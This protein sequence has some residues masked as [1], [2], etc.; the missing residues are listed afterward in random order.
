M[1]R[2]RLLLSNKHGSQLPPMKP[3]MENV[4]LTCDLAV[5]DV[6]LLTAALRDLH[7]RYPGRFQTGLRT[8]FHE[9]YEHNP[10][11][12]THSN[13]SAKTIECSY[14]LIE[15]SN[16]APYH[17]IHGFHKFLGEQLGV[18]IEPTEFKGDV[19]L[20]GD[21]KSWDSQVGELMGEEIPFWI[22]VAGGK[23]DVTIKWWETRRYQEVVDHLRGK[24]QF[25]Q[26]GA[27][28]HHH[29]KLDGVIDLRGQTNLRQLIR[30]MYHAQGVLCPVTLAMH[31]AAAVEVKGGRPKNRPCVVIAG[32]REPAQWEAYPHHQYIHTNGALLCCDNGAA[33]NPEPCHWVMAMNG[34]GRKTCVWMSS[35]AK[36]RC[37]AAWT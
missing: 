16:T 31:L 5:G 4:T 7:F 23:Y 20:T 1:K 15:R 11:V 37:H 12:T 30:L 17:V 36:R 28:E 22:L 9:V 25:V 8:A 2:R 33:G 18:H 35:T 29:P 24:I 26:I 6:V 10:F 19:H 27:R 14:P 3:T 34:T 32:G 13:G 21:E